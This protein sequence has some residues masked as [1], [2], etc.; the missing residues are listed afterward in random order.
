MSA[1]NVLIACECSQRVANSFRNLGDNAFSCDL[2]DCYGGHPEY[3]IKS[4]VLNVLHAPTQFYTCDGKSHH[5]D[6]WDLVVAHPPCTYLC[7][8]QS[9]LY[10]IKRLGA[11]Y[12]MDRILKRNDAAEFF[13]EFTRLNIPTLIEN[14]VGYMTKRFRKPDQYI[15]PYMFGEHAT[16]KTGLW[17]FDLPKLIPTNIVSV[18]D[19]HVFP[20]SNSMGEWYYKTSCLPFKERARARSE[21]FE[22]IAKAIAKQYHDYLTGDAL[23]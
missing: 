18:P 10:D 16:K 17:L 7:R 8:A 19:V 9:N 22:G 15:E 5:I 23:S 6:R 2:V 13:M 20:S 4:D 3:H 1:L 14:P 11:Q 21:T 12:V